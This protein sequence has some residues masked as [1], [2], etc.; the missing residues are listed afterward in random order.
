MAIADAFAAGVPSLPTPVPICH[1]GQ[2]PS[3]GG[4]HL[5]IKKSKTIPAMHVAAACI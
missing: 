3:R 1:G 4:R 5:A 2:E